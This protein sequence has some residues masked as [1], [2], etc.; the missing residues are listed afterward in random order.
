MNEPYQPQN[1]NNNVLPQSTMA[2]VSLVAGILGFTLF[3]VIASIVAIFTGYA[4]R[5]ETRSVS[6]IAS[7]D[8]MA[9]AGIIMGWI[10]I[11]LAVVSICCLVVYFVFVIGLVGSSAGQY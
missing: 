9:T 6:P 5:K 7:G 11:G 4:A 10:Q 1:T 2:I 3:P 8:G